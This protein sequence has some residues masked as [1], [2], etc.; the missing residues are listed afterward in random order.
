[1]NQ[2]KS[3]QQLSLYYCLSIENKLYKKLVWPQYRWVYS[4]DYSRQINLK[5]S[6]ILSY[7]NNKW[8]NVIFIHYDSVLTTRVVYLQY[9]ENLFLPSLSLISIF[10][11]ITRARVL[12]LFMV[13]QRYLLP[14]LIVLLFYH[15]NFLKKLMLFNEFNLKWILFF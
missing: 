12:Y 9:S 10:E 14:Y 15:Y 1:M 6:Y 2:P 7:K 11:G 4:I 5:I 13:F 3:N 8:K